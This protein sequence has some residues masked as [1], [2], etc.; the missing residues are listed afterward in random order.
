MVLDVG[1]CRCLLFVV[2]CCVR[3]VVCR[4]LLF[5]G[6]GC[7]MLFDVVRCVLW[8]VV[9]Y[10]LLFVVCGLCSLLF[11]VWCGRF[12]LLVLSCGVFMT[13]VVVGVLLLCDV[14]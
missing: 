13:F 3:F 11:V 2:V 14:C 8:F 1:V 4:L 9:V 6:E 12:V 7:C 10:W 5:S